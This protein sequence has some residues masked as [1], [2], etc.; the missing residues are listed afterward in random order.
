MIHCSLC[1]TTIDYLKNVK[2]H[3]EE[4][5]SRKR[6]FQGQMEDTAK[7]YQKSIKLVLHDSLLVM[8]NFLNYLKLPLSA[9]WKLFS[10]VSIVKFHS[11]EP[12]L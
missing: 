5:A 6:K 11:Y 9:L 2:R 10:D 12:N 8:I 4:S 3:A 7:L 1:P